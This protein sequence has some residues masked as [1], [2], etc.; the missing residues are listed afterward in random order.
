MEDS[1]S[2]YNQLIF[3]DN[4]P[5]ENQLSLVEVTIWFRTDN[6][7]ILATFFDAMLQHYANT[8]IRHGPL[9]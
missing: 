6:M 1:I 7:P 3:V 5:I 2:V 4:V 8:Q 9:L